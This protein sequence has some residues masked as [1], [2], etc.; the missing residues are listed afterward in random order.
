MSL[1]YRKPLNK[2]EYHTLIS[3]PILKFFGLDG[4]NGLASGAA[5]ALVSFLTGLVS[6]FGA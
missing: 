4:N 6:F 3:P 5:F 2:V 1:R